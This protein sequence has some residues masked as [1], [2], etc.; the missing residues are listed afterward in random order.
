MKYWKICDVV[1]V[2][3]FILFLSPMYYVFLAF[4]ASFTAYFLCAPQE[5]NFFLHLEGIYLFYFKCVLCVHSS[6]LVMDYGKE[7]LE[8]RDMVTE[9]CV[10]LDELLGLWLIK[11]SECLEL[12]E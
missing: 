6:E 12:R 1:A 4:W 9:G 10:I 11:R 8:P 3:A 7:I 2:C 5:E